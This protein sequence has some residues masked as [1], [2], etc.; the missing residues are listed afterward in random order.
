M[1]VLATGPEGISNYVHAFKSYIN[2]TQS[3]KVEELPSAIG[4]AGEIVMSFM[5]DRNK[6]SWVISLTGSFRVVKPVVQT[7]FCTVI[8]VVVSQTNAEQSKG[9]DYNKGNSQDVHGGAHHHSTNL[10]KEKE[11]RRVI[12]SPDAVCYICHLE[13]VP[14]KNLLLCVHSFC[15]N[16]DFCHS[17]LHLSLL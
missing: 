15:H 11:S 1:S 14:G 2:N 9:S 5:M 10:Q 4:K 8:P 3:I 12:S 17:T 6:S 7:P 16:I 13:G